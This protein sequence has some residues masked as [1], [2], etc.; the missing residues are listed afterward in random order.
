[1]AREFRPGAEA[2]R[3]L[4]GGVII[5]AEIG[6]DHHKIA[7]FGDTVNTTARLESLCKSLGKQ[8]LISSELA[9]RIKLPKTLDIED[10]GAHAVKGRGQ[11][12]GVMALKQLQKVEVVQRL[13]LPVRPNSESLRPH[14]DGVTKASSSRQ[15]TD[16][17]ALLSGTSRF[18]R[19]MGT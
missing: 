13:P 7:F 16:I 6:V 2:A 15:F 12:L 19:S 18:N 9:Q 1:M 14:T 10:L 3:R 17:N 4:H 11:T 8:V 5:T